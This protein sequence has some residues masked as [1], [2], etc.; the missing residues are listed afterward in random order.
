M[1]PSW[2]DSFKFETVIS[3]KYVELSVINVG[4]LQSNTE[5]GSATIDINTFFTKEGQTVAIQIKNGEKII[6]NVYIKVIKSLPNLKALEDSLNAQAKSLADKKEW[7]NE[8]IQI[9]EKLNS[10]S[11][12]ES[13]QILDKSERDFKDTCYKKLSPP[14]VLE[15]IEK[16]KETPEY[17]S[18]ECEDKK[19][20]RLHRLTSDSY[21]CARCNKYQFV[22][23]MYSYTFCAD[24]H[25]GEGRL[26][27]SDPDC[28]IYET[29]SY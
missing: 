29:Y 3:E 12:G 14:E 10:L 27:C 21:L 24:D 1:I 23:H 8:K 28:G 4:K 17:K 26:I 5:L 11:V 18:K 25:I 7:M 13:L 20:K 15:K 19:N 2:N 16:I 9:K 6:G 22:E